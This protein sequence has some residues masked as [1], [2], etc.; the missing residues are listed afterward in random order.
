MVNFQMAMTT[1]STKL[2]KTSHVDG[3]ALKVI[4]HEGVFPRSVCFKLCYHG[5][6]QIENINWTNECFLADQTSKY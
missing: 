3:V 6:S 5:Q 4:S 2:R 1:L